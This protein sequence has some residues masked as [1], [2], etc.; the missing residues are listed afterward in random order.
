MH[1]YLCNSKVIKL[2]FSPNIDSS[3]IYF[4]IDKIFFA[5]KLEKSSKNDVEYNFME[6]TE[7][8]R[9]S[10]CNEVQA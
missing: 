1:M 5:Q 8:S 2:I 6:I 10:F 7:S 3:N 9:R 4:K